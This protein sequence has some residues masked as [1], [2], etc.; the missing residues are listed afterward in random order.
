MAD[1]Y[2]LK[3]FGSAGN[4]KKFTISVWLKQVQ[5]IKTSSN[6]VIFS[7]GSASNTYGQIRYKSGYI[8]FEDEQ[9]GSVKATPYTTAHFVDPSAWYHLVVRV[10]TTQSTASDRI[11]FYRN[12]SQLTAG[13]GSQPSQNEDLNMNNNIGH[14]LGTLYRGSDSGGHWN[15]H[16][17]QFIFCDGQSYAPSSFAATDANGIWAPNASPSLTYGSN[18]FRIDFK[19]T[20][21]SADASGFGADTSGNSNHF[22]TTN[23]G[24]N[25]SS[26][27]SPTNNFSVFNMQGSN[28]SSITEGGLRMVGDT[29]TSY[30]LGACS[31]IAFQKGKWYAE[32]KILDDSSHNIGLCKEG[33]M[34]SN[35]LDYQYQKGQLFYRDNGNRA[36]GTG[37]GYGTN[38]SYG[39]TYTTGDI[40]GVAAD[41]DNRNLY[42]YKNGTIQNSGTAAFT[43]S[44]ISGQAD[45]DIKADTFYSFFAGGY[46]DGIVQANFG[47]PSFTI[48]SSNADANG[49]GSFEYAV[50]SG[51]YALCTKNLAQYGG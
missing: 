47:N 15:G 50:P 37:S 43:S 33:N 19:G 35:A 48:S 26:K 42:F 29:G 2:L 28:A 12:G 6:F 25:P 49:Y 10:D 23:I 4:R 3:T 8:Q 44:Q 40:I 34:M 7:A 31:S 45:S 5:G 16:M 27:D 22:A 30:T 36:S 32:F 9:S 39:D 46:N 11:R 13:G 1:T 38:G 21:A 41:M 24:T 20:G 14:A 17:A 18:G 51:Y